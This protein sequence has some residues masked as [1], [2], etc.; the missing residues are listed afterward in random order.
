MTDEGDE[1]GKSLR[2]VTVLG[3]IIFSVLLA[4]GIATAAGQ[5]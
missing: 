4:A 1:V 3:T 5:P 2:I